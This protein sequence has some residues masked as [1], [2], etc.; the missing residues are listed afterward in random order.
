MEGA[1]VGQQNENDDLVISSIKAS[2]DLKCLFFNIRSLKAHNKFD[3][4]KQMV[5]DLGSFDIICLVET[6]LTQPDIPFYFIPGY[7]S[8]I[9]GMAG[10]EGVFHAL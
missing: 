1:Y 6:W 5:V 2:Q 3:E 10:G 9:T 8:I 7:V 4:L